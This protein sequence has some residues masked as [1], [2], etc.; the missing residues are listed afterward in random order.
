M[1]LIY[2]FVCFERINWLLIV[3]WLKLQHLSND[4]S[5]PT[6]CKF[7]V[8]IP[9]RIYA[10]LYQII[11]TAFCYYSTKTDFSILYL[12]NNPN[13]KLLFCHFLNKEWERE[14]AMGCL[15]HFSPIFYNTVYLFVCLITLADFFGWFRDV[16]TFQRLIVNYRRGNFVI[17]IRDV[18]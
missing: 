10:F 18:H 13:F 4:K 12:L 17:I 7:E 1:L 2:Y 16:Q 5:F 14:W 8:R 9:F 11:R 6:F 3:Q 15:L